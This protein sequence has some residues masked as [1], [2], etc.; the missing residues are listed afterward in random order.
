MKPVWAA[1]PTVCDRKLC[2]VVNTPDQECLT[3]KQSCQDAY[4]PTVS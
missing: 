2:N 4:V 3:Q 1:Q